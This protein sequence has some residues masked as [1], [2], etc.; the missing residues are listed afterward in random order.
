MKLEGRVWKYGDNINT[1]VIFPGKYTYTV[2]GRSEIASHA[3]EDLDP[4][5]VK[6]VQSGDIIVAGRNWGCGSSREQAASCLVYNGVGAVIAESFSRI[7]YRNAL[8]NGLLAITCPGAAQVIQPGEIVR[9]DLARNVVQCAA[10]EF[11]YPPLSP[12]I[13]GIVQAGGLVEYVKHKLATGNS[14]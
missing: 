11:A 3:L 10:G 8:N 9:I 1:D 12:S 13:M 2:T 6:N 4:T 7:F 5:F 14:H